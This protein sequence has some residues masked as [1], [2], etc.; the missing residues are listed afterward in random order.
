MSDYWIRGFPGLNGS[1]LTTSD[2]HNNCCVIKLRSDTWN[3]RILLIKEFKRDWIWQ[4]DPCGS[5]QSLNTFLKEKK[6]EPARYPNRYRECEEDAH[7][8]SR[9]W[10]YGRRN[11]E[12]YMSPF[13][14]PGGSISISFTLVWTPSQLW[15]R[16]PMW[17]SESLEYNAS[18]RQHRRTRRRI[19]GGRDVTYL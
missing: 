17:H 4:H 7:A 3:Q 14:Q 13:H 16:L 18:E 15:R 9:L 1:V 10:I 6:T 5:M 8:N 19:L 11:E 2:S 12:E